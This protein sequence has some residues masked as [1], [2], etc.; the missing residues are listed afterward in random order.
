MSLPTLGEG[1]NKMKMETYVCMCGQIIYLE[2]NDGEKICLSCAIKELKK[3]EEELL[4][5]LKKLSV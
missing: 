3:A 2:K 5:G 1:V 4:C